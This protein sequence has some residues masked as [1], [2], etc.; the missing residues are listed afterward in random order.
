MHQFFFV[1]SNR[2]IDWLEHQFYQMGLHDNHMYIKVVRDKFNRQTDRTLCFMNEKIYTHLL[3]Q[4][5]PDLKIE[6]FLTPKNFHPNLQTYTYNFC[7]PFPSLPEDQYSNSNRD[8]TFVDEI[9]DKLQPFIF[10][11]IIPYDS[12]SLHIPVVSREKNETKGIAFLTFHSSIDKDILANIRYL[13]D[14]TKWKDH[15]VMRCLWGKLSTKQ[16]HRNQE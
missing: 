9:K 3:Q 11:G 2:T 6:P 8:K 5:R 7:I 10:H 16:A 15:S 14:G 13:L 1:K 12:Y 4:T